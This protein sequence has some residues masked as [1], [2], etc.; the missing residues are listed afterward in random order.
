MESLHGCRENH[1]MLTEMMREAKHQ[2]R[3][4]TLCWIDLANAYGS[5]QHNLIFLALEHY[6]LPA[7]FVRLIKNMNFSLSVLILT[8]SWSTS[9]FPLQVGIFQGDPLSVVIFNL[10]INLYVEFSQESY[11]QLGY[12]FSGSS[13]TVPLLQYADDSCLVSNSVENCQNLCSW[14]NMKAKV[15]EC[16][17]QEIK[18]SKVQNTTH[19][20]LNNSPIPVVDSLGI[21]FLALPISN[22]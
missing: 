7:H 9:S 16:N 14:A 12:C 11:L 3:N 18:R 13:Y 17:V 19:R 6:H 8:N 20:V 4:L 5:V 15:P 10:V 21:K 2:Q 22:S 1:L